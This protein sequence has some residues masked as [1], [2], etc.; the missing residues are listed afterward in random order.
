MHLAKGRCR[1]GMSGKKEVDGK[2]CPFL[3]RRVCRRYK[4]H[5][6]HSRHGCKQGKNCPR[7]HPK[8]CEG[9]Q[10]KVKER[11]CLKEDCPHLHLKGTRRT[12]PGPEKHGHGNKE[13]HRPE[14]QAWGTAPKLPV[15]NPPPRPPSQQNPDQLQSGF[16]SIV[17]K[18]VRNA[19]EETLR[20]ADR[21]EEIM[22]QLGATHDESFTHPQIIQT[23]HPQP[24]HYTIPGGM[25]MTQSPHHKPS[26]KIQQSRRSL[27]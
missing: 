3:H 8:L 23:V 18:E 2:V 21:M 13:E 6:L 24:V 12:A 4:A 27:Y 14:V 11:L 20:Q 16:L 9:S 1:Q 25:M 19:R 26:T 7:L 17:L 10:R 22:S 5:G 15:G